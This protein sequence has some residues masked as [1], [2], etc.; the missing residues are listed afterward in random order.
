MSNKQAAI[1]I[2]LM[3]CLMAAGCAKST[4]RTKQ[5]DGTYRTSTHLIIQ[6]DFADRS[7][8]SNKDYMLS[9]EFND[10]TYVWPEGKGNFSR[11]FN[12]INFKGKNISCS[13]IKRRLTINGRPAE[14][15]HFY[16]PVNNLPESMGEEEANEIKVSYKKM[17][18]GKLIP[19]INRLHDFI[20]DKYLPAGRETSGFSALL[21]GKEWYQHQIKLYASTDMTADEVF[22]LGKSEV[23]R[24]KRE[25]EQVKERVGFAGDL[26]AF[27]DHVRSKPELMP[28]D[29][30]QQVIDHF[31]AIHEKMKPNLEKLFD[32]KP[33]TAFE[34]R[35]TE[36]FREASASAEYNPGSLDGTRPGVFYVPIP[37]VKS[38]NVYSD[39]DLF[40]HEAI[41]GHHYQISLAQ[42]NEQFPS[43][44]A[45]S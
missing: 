23:A 6:P 3:L 37:N 15:H 2:T 14:S 26:K 24:L 17:I 10:V 22:E 18:E 42:E 29:D 40:L 33:K 34:V 1:V 25:M 8:S 32:Q 30:P 43:F 41:P 27:F 12:E 35:R 5:N 7:F 38:Y 31:N 21:N 16:S 39:E 20:Q 45:Q 44:K 9:T 19:A 36:A 11:N 28:F 13:I 4:V